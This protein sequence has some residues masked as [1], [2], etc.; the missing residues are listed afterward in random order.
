MWI[1]SATVR[2][3]FAEIGALSNAEIAEKAGTTPRT[4]HRALRE[5]DTVTPA[6]ARK[7]AAALGVPVSELIKFDG[8]EPT[9]EEMISQAEPA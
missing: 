9:E 2:Q 7:F 3:L 4:T 8:P 6:T 5:N 1:K